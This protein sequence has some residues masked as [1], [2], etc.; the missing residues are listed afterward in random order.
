MPLPVVKEPELLELDELV[1]VDV[2]PDAETIEEDP[3]LELALLPELL[4][5]LDSPKEAWARAPLARRREVARVEMKCMM[6]MY[7]VEK[8]LALCC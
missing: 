3:L 2:L 5:P 7:I 6:K 8:R 4:P 1:P